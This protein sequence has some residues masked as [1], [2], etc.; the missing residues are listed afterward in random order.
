VLLL[1]EMSRYGPGSK[2]SVATIIMH[3]F[4]LTTSFTLMLATL[5]D[6]GPGKK[7][8]KPS[9]IHSDLQGSFEN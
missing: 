9:H 2:E 7:A 4:L 3:S 1:V 6:Y 5:D 8:V